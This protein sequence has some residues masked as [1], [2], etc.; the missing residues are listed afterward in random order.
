M[1]EKQDVIQR[2][3]ISYCE[4]DATAPYLQTTISVKN[5]FLY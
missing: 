1:N 2:Q 4:R 3:E 5:V